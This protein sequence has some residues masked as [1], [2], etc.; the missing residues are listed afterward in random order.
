MGPTP[1]DLL[2]TVLAYDDARGAP[3]ANAP[4]SGYQRI[5]AGDTAL[6]MD[7]GRPPPV[8]LSQE[9]HAG[10]LS[11]ELSW[12]HSRAGG[13]LRPAGGQQ[14]ELAA[15]RARDR[16]AF[17]RRPSTTPRR[18]VS[19]NRLVAQAA[20]RHAHRR[21]PAPRHASSASDRRTGNGCAPAHDGYAPD[22][23]VIHSRALRL[24][25]RRPPARRRGQLPPG[26]RR[27]A[28]GA[29]GATNSPSAFTCIRR[30]RPTGCPTATASSCCCPTRNCGPSTPSATRCEI[31]ESVFLAS[32]DGPRRTVQIV[33]YGKRARTAGGALEPR[34]SPPAAAWRAR[35]ADARS[36]NCRCRLACVE[37]VSAIHFRPLPVLA[38]EP[39]PAIRAAS[40]ALCC[41]SPTRRGLVDFAKALAGYGVELVSTGGTAKALQG[42]RA[43]GHRRRRAHRLSRDDG[44]PGQDAASESA[45]RPAGDARQQGARRRDGAARHQADRSAGGEPLSVRGDRRQGRVFRRLHREHRHRRAGHDPRRRQEPRRRHGR[46]RAGGL[47]ARAGRAGAARRHDHARAAP[48]AGRQGLCAHRRLRRGDLQLVCRNAAR[49]RRR[50]I[51][52]SAAG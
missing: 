42:R 46:G 36:R 33:I 27:G 18:A 52:P 28:A 9:A 23:G 7:T 29:R 30:S 10:C 3:V 20:V 26:R 2:A 40:P 4:H 8:A 47:R 11:F 50:T 49:R 43:H 38:G 5:D 37:P 6:I 34:H 25:R 31:E 19:W 32:P 35:Q 12:R 44:R 13:Q 1:V 24:A 41:R 48:E 17:D 45:R 16:R 51:A 15:G 21:R 14:G 22:F 39:W